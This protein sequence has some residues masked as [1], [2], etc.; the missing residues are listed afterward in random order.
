MQENIKYT[1]ALSLVPNIGPVIAKQL[2]QTF[3]NDAKALFETP[4]KHLQEIENLGTVR[5]NA[6][7]KFNDWKTVDSEINFT[8]KHKIDIHPIYANTYPNNLKQCLDAPI[9]LY[10][11]GNLD[12]NATK[13]ISVVGKR[14]N[15][16]YGKRI[17]EEIVAYAASH[18]ATIISGLAFGIDIIAHKAALANN[19]ATIGVLAHGL[20]RIYPDVHRNTAKDML[21]HGGL[22]TE[23]ISGTKPDREN[24]PTRNR[25]VA[26]MA[27]VTIIIETDMK[28]GSMI[29]AQLAN[30]YNK[31]VMAVPGSIYIDT[32]KGCNFLIRQHQAHILT[33]P[34]DIAR[35]LNWE[36]D[37]KKKK[38]IQRSLFIELS[39][40]EQ[41]VVDTLNENG[42][43]PIDDLIAL[44]QLTNAQ[45]ASVLLSLEMQQIISA[46]PG[47]RYQMM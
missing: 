21:E 46:L 9:I 17:T 2:L 44:T 6:I 45:I 38:P 42:I 22:L 14:K 40:E 27:D 8:E 31:E 7:K 35:L 37:T 1:I 12:L 41:K 43:V 20:D 36:T 4:T 15:T 30:S 28:G 16:D 24:F 13:T 33:T 39:K 29:T 19:T 25:I 11:K 3:N 47:K 23:F 32:S 10:S 5:I 18:K 34:T 26:G